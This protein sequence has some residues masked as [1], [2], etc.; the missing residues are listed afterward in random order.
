MVATLN[1]R[2]LGRK[3][4]IQLQSMNLIYGPILVDNRIIEI[5]LAVSI[6][7][8]I[9]RS[10]AIIN[11]RFIYI[12]VKNTIAFAVIRIKYYYNLYY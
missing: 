9:I 11:Y 10:I 8:A 2:Y 3:S 6:L 5:H 7:N 12:D 4:V 1:T